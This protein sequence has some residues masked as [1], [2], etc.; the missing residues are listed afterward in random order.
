VV[1]GPEHRRTH[2]ASTLIN[3][4]VSQLERQ[5]YLTITAAVASDLAVAQAFY[6]HNGFTARLSQPGGQARNRRIILRTRN[7]E[8]ESLFSILEPPTAT[9]QTTI[10][11]GLRKRSAGQAPLYAID[12]NVL[13]DIVRDR[14]RPRAPVAERLIG[15]ALAHQMR[16]TVAPELIV[17][18][19]RKTKGEDVDP[20]L[21]LARQL[22]RLPPVDRKESDRLTALVHNIAFV[23]T[24]S[25]KAG[26]PQALS[27]ARH[28]AEAALARASGY[29]TSDGQ[30]LAV[31]E[32]LLQQ[33]GIDVASLEE[34]AELLP[35]ETS[36]SS[37]S[38]LKGTDCA[39]KPASVEIVRQYLEDNRAPASVIAEFCPA[40]SERAPWRGLAVTE[41]GDVVAVGA[42]IM[43]HK[44]DA[45]ARVLVHARA[46][47]V[48]CDIFADYL[49]DTQCREACRSG[50]T[51]IEL[52]QIPGQAAVRRASILHGFLPLPKADTLI[53]VALGRPVTSASWGA[54]ARQTRRRTGL[55]L[56]EA[57]PNESA[58]T[59]GYEICGPDGKPVRVRLTQLEDALGPTILVWPGRDGVIVPIAKNFADDLLG[60]GDQLPLF[61]SPEAAFVARRTYFN[62]PRTASLMRPGAPI[63]FYESR[64]SGGRGIIAAARIADATVVDKRQVSDELLRRAVVEDLEPLSASAEVLA[65]TFDNLLRFPV[66]VPLEKLRELEA[67]GNSNLQTTT[68]LSHA[69]LNAI[70]ELGWTRA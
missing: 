70:L 25:S 51:T 8:T 34:F 35:V 14:T 53:K 15:A 9:A 16:L 4:L 63:L 32:K 13:F 2:I 17:E 69:A 10:D 56:P 64:R 42:S 23:E 67:E 11:L 57:P 38:H 19:E 21:R 12:L 55:Q 43:P 54:I 7:L 37:H 24:K 66:P 26:T 3:D 59:V 52:P 41:A 61:G 49:L 40:P 28:L 1:V 47:H 45:P 33:I 6:E 44:I 20:I 65:T 58:V 29:V 36:A 62:S 68:P 5:A 31:R 50:P 46:D 30:L 39:A 60:T 18:L 48:A 22:P 27:D